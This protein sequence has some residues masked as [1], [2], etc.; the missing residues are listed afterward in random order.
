MEK[1]TLHCELMLMSD[2]NHSTELTCLSL[3]VCAQQVMFLKL[4]VNT[5]VS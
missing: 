3:P 4:K 1:N 2:N 5:Q